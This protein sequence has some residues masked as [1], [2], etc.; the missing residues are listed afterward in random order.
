[1]SLWNVFQNDFFQLMNDKNIESR[2]EL[3]HAYDKKN[4]M[5]WCEHQYSYR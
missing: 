3:L 1:M 2:S 4:V 5:F